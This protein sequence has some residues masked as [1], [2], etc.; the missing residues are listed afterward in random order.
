MF[1]LYILAS[2]DDLDYWLWGR[3][4]EI[5]VPFLEGNGINSDPIITLANGWKSLRSF[6]TAN[7]SRGIIKMFHLDPVEVFVDLYGDEDID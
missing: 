1:I 2:F 6:I 5:L 7:L 3:V 4:L